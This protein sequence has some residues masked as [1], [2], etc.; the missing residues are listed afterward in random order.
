MP[1][2][3]VVEAYPCMGLIMGQVERLPVELEECELA[4][5]WQQEAFSE[6]TRGQSRAEISE[7]SDES[8]NKTPDWLE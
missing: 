2:L 8:A 3:R 5:L 1:K 7:V 6:P 4:V